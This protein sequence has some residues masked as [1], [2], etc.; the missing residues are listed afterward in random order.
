[1]GII[2]KQLS[3]LIKIIDFQMKVLL[4]YSSGQSLQVHYLKAKP[5]KPVFLQVTCNKQ[6][7]WEVFK[8]SFTEPVS[9]SFI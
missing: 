3:K 2:T 8:D 4:S 1:M 5:T 6:K 9:H 7:N